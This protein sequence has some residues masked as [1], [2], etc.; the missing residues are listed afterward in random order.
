MQK[1]CTNITASRLIFDGQKIVAGV[2]TGLVGKVRTQL[3]DYQLLY[4]LFIH[5][6]IHQQALCSKVSDISCELAPIVSAVN[7]IWALLL[8]FNLVFVLISEACALVHSSAWLRCGKVLF[9]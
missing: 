3:T 5:W 2:R 6:I 8:I 4:T 1:T 9:F 7:F